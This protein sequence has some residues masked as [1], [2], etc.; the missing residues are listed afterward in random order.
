MEAAVQ[1]QK[2]QISDR[3][4]VYLGTGLPVFFIPVHA[5]QETL[6]ERIIFP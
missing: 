2:Q 4:P 5:A 1:L 3:K 6:P